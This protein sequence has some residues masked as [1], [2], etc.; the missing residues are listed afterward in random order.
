M[1][2]NIILDRMLP[3]L[4]LTSRP[5]ANSMPNV[6]GSRPT[7]SSV[8]PWARSGQTVSCVCGA[9]LRRGGCRITA[10][11]RRRGSP[12]FSFFVHAEFECGPGRR[13][14]A[15]LDILFED[16]RGRRG[17]SL[18]EQRPEQ[19]RTNQRRH[20][21]SAH[22]QPAAENR[23]AG[24]LPGQ[25]VSYRCHP[26]AAARAPALFLFVCST[27][28]MR[29][30]KGRRSATA[31]RS[32][33]HRWR[34]ANAWGVRASRRGV[35]PASYWIDGK[36]R[37]LFVVSGVEISVLKESNGSAASYTLRN[38]PVRPL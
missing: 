19:A 12:G 17:C 14:I 9:N 4:M 36:N 30:A 37:V 5:E 20:D 10:D 3:V 35:I 32:S 26:A 18:S 31:A 24:R 33:G 28:W 23:G 29:F 38:P 1:P 21:G 16:G 22:W 7:S 27:R 13:P 8:L 34:H 25:V 15:S 11:S 2:Q 6:S